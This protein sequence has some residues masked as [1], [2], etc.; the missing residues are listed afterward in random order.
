MNN[1][2]SEALA[3]I[4]DRYWNFVREERPA[5]ALLAGQPVG[6]QLMREAPADHER[7]AVE[8]LR[9]LDEL[10]PIHA[11][12]L[13]PAERAT[14]LLLRHEL[15][16]M[17]EVVET[18]GH[19]R[20]SLFP[21]GPEFVLGYL[22]NSVTLF[23][24]EDAEAWLA[25]LA[26][27]P[28]GLAGV[29]ECLRAGKALG[30]HQPKLA[31]DAA[32]NNVQGALAADPATSPFHGPVLRAAAH[33]PEETAA[34]G[35]ALV[36]DTVFPALRDYAAFITNELLPQAR[37]S[38]GCTD[39]PQGPPYYQMLIRQFATVDDTPE[40]IHELG[41]S[42][43]ARLSAEAVA[44]AAEAGF[45][46]DLAGFKASLSQPDQF[47]PS[48]DALREEI[49]LLSKRIDAKLPGLFGR[50]PRMTYDVQ[51]IPEAL[52]ERM[53]V[54]YAQPNPADKASPGI[55]WITSH[56]AKCPRYLHLPLELHE[57]WP[58]HL[59]HLAL[60]QEQESLP[61]F[62]R[63]GATEYSACLEGWALYCERLGE[64]MGLYDTAQK[65]YGAVEMEMWRAVR[66]VVDTGVH[67]KGW[68][69]QQGID[70]ASIHLT[71][72]R[73]TIEA[74]V[75][76][77]I[78]LPGQALAYQIG[79]LKFRE[80]RR[81]AQDRLGERFRVR[82]FHD[83]LMACGA[84]TLPVLEDLIDAWIATQ[85]VS[86]APV[87]EAADETH[88]VHTTI[89]NHV[90]LGIETTAETLW[91]TILDEYVEAKKFRDSG[92]LTSI[93][94]PAVPL[95]GY[96]MRVEQAGTV[97]ERIIHITELDHG[98]RRLSIFANYLTVPAQGMQVFVTYQAQ[99]GPDGTRFAIESHTQLHV[100]A[101]KGGGKSEISAAIA[102]LKSV[103]DVGLNAYLDKIKTTLEGAKDAKS[104]S[105]GSSD[106]L[107]RNSA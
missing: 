64:E 68:S 86:G 88:S 55:H 17:R 105:Q 16:L 91:H 30:V 107:G 100:D 84:V 70:F 13:P 62:R 44:L 33:L 45:P 102:E 81:R 1:T 103:F 40:A 36:R 59:M 19:L 39:A 54:A 74:E 72:P 28:T 51:S 24:Q 4:A 53:P 98:A 60:I 49:E 42:E 73:V 85:A 2:A 10:A 92:V 26:S 96:R 5:I 38:V 83:A 35:L 27:V 15:K 80:L 46:D 7:R 12:G 25:R 69:R 90:G 20:P 87:P 106:H 50:L 63:F 14:L 58:G 61:A 32:I 94:D 82:D 43:V 57:A 89:V 48:A 22:A 3:R 67:A 65:R 97:D 71:L 47:A 23:S 8:A 41:L 56:P 6:D 11:D 93:D 34:R 29:Q 66:L 79:N 77:Y 101:P 9:F 99:Q 18:H 76:R 52:S 75:D 37:T 21:L 31:L 78:A 104:D 95:G